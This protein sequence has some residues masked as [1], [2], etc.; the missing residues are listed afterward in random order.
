[1]TLKETGPSALSI[2]FKLNIFENSEDMTVS[3]WKKS[4]KVSSPS[5]VNSKSLGS[6]KQ[7]IINFMAIP[8][9][10]ANSLDSSTSMQPL[11]VLVHCLV[12]TT[13]FDENKQGVERVYKA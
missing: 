5:G 12:A 1:M 10:I 7:K 2:Q 3:I 8:P 9:L 6:S 4:K 13:I 11:N